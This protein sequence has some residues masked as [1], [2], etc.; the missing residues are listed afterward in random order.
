MTIGDVFGMAA[1][2]LSQHRRRTSLSLLGVAMG[3]TAVIFLTGLGE[4]ARRYVVGEFASLGSNL[5]IVIPGKTETTGG[6][7]GVGGAPNDLTLDDARAIERRISGARRVIPVALGNDMVSHLERRRQ[8]I[9]IG[10]TAEFVPARQL[11]IARG[12]NLPTGPFERGAPVAVIGDKVARELFR[13]ADP[14]GKVIRAGDARMRVIGVLE[15]RGKQ[16][17]QDLDQIVLAPVATVMQIFNRSSLFRILIEVNAHSDSDRIQEQVIALI[18]ERHDEED[19]TCITQEAVIDS[20]GGILRA[21]TMAVGGIGAISLAVAGIGIMNVMLVSVSERTAEVGLMKALGARQRQILAVF[22]VEAAMLSTA[23]GLLGLALGAGL[24]R[25]VTLVYPAVPAVT[26][27]W[28]V[29]G[30]LG[31]TIFTGPLF[32]VMPAWRAMK[33]EPVTALASR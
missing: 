25:I 18:S 20:L 33:L 12:R 27:I 4:G 28:A 8:L 1:R 23:G 30:V 11:A 31:L 10:T 32:G 13:D 29:L 26:P 16:M 24:L 17:G 19:I 15:K 6:F 21:L 14:I 22:L 5:V 2:A 9:V 7:P 3:A